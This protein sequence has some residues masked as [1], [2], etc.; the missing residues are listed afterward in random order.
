MA[1]SPLSPA[2]SR[3]A[4]SLSYLAR[5]PVKK[6]KIDRSFIDTLGTSPQ[7]SAIGSSIVG[8]GRSLHLTITAEGVETEGQAEILRKWGCNQ[9]Q[10]FY[11]GR[12][13]AD[14]PESEEEIAKQPQVA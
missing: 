13:E 11:Y 7:T 5:L 9:V 3:D 10:G 6:I 2:C 12:P 1:C 8:L 4:P 14:V